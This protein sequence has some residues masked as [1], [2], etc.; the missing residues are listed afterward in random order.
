MFASFFLVAVRA[1]LLV[2]YI[3][4]AIYRGRTVRRLKKICALKKYRLKVSNPF[5]SY[6]RNF[7]DKYD[8]TVNTGKT[9][10]A[11]KFFDE[12]Y[13]NSTFVFREDRR[14]IRAESSSEIFDQTKRRRSEREIGVFPKL[15]C[16]CAGKR[17]VR[18][19]LLDADSIEVL[20][21]ENG[22][23]KRL[24]EGDEL[25]GMRLASHSSFLKVI[26]R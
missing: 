3:T 10:Y 18:L 2:P 1:V 24:K 4:R 15:S 6:F 22:K 20:L 25:Y 13:Q 16:D 26:G 23:A 21:E 8:L 12:Y 17:E 9:V 14:V 11:V 5:S 19:L 7:S